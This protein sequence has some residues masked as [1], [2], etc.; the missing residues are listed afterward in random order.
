MNLIR[1]SIPHDV[2]RMPLVLTRSCVDY[3]DDYYDFSNDFCDEI[4]IILISNLKYITFFHYMEHR[5]MLCR[6]LEKILL[7]KTL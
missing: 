6:K 1:S 7:K 2:Y 5:S 3:L 4:K